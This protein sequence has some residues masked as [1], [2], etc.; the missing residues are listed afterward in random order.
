MTGGGKDARR[1]EV[2]GAI[3]AGGAGSRFGG[4]PK[5][6]EVVG[7]QRIIDRVANALRGV[8][9]ELMVVSN[10][11]GADAWLPKARVERDARAG[12]GSLIGIHAA[13]THARGPVIV[14]AWDMPFVSTELVTLLRDRGRDAQHAVIPVTDRGLEPCCAWYSPSS[15]PAI[16]EM[17]DAGEFRLGALADHL[18]SIDVV[19][20][21]ELARIGDPSQLFF[22]VN[23][24]ADLE[25]ATSMMES[26]RAQ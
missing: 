20:P 25:H 8:V 17:I 22:N 5:G 10:A 4:K 23:T 21:R 19:T 24:S 2:A 12:R 11:P 1:G 16:D 26:P 3:L 6:L 7:G 13:I 15:L 9:S 14:V 18:P